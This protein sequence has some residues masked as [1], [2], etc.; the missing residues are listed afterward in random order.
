M[1]FYDKDALDKKYLDFQSQFQRVSLVVVF[2]SAL[3]YGVIALLILFLFTVAVIIY[4][5][6]GNSIFFHRQEIEIIELV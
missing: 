3:E 5:V 6:I 2:L 1:L 4:T